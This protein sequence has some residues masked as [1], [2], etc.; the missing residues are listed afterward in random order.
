MTPT[1][2]K[3]TA[4]DEG[5][6]IALIAHRHQPPGGACCQRVSGC[7]FTP[8]H[9]GSHQLGAVVRTTEARFT[10][11]CRGVGAGGLKN[12]TDGNIRIATDTIQSVI[13]GI[14]SCQSTK[15]AR[16]PLYQRQPRLP[17]DFARRK[18]RLTTTP[19]VWLPPAKDLQTAGCPRR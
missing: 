7:D 1:W 15:T 14:T 11:S 5:L 17:R 18:E 4:V 6:R 19:P 3:A 8:V 13:V 9:R 12:G 10:A 16:W 2:M